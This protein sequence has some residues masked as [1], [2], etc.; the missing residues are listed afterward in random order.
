MQAAGNWTHGIWKSGQRR[1]TLQIWPLAHGGLDVPAEPGATCARVHPSDITH[2]SSIA[3]E[4]CPSSSLSPEHIC[5]TFKRW[6][7]PP[8]TAW[9]PYRRGRFAWGSHKFWF[10][11]VPAFFFFSFIFM[12]EAKFFFL[13]TDITAKILHDFLWRFFMCTRFI[14]F[15]FYDVCTFKNDWA[16]VWDSRQTESESLQPVKAASVF[17][18]DSK[19]DRMSSIDRFGCSITTT[20]V[21]MK[22]K[23]FYMHRAAFTV[24]IYL[25]CMRSFFSTSICFILTSYFLLFPS[26]GSY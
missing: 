8:G 12:R 13:Y 6:A 17:Q 4:L 9:S 26:L 15:F 16:L 25:L 20:T 3:G 18:R 5:Q 24:C 11:L 19:E 14:W 21:K 23:R 10:D 7:L 1:R 2:H 22:H